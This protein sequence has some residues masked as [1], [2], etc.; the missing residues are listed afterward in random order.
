MKMLTESRPFATTPLQRACAI[1]ALVLVVPAQAAG[2]LDGRRFVGDTG[3]IGQAATEK[4]D[5]ITF[6]GGRFHSAQCDQW[7]FGKGE[8]RATQYGDAIRF[9]TTTVSG[10]HG[11]LQWRG[12]VRGSALEGTFTHHRKPSWWRPNPEPLE[13]WVRATAQR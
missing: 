5:V 13:Y 11:R 4:G 1:V 2:L 12:S 3:P 6:A 8:Y 10:E 9:E 7:G